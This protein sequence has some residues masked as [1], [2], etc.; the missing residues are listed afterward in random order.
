MKNRRVIAHDKVSSNNKMY[1][2]EKVWYSCNNSLTSY[3]K[4]VEYSIYGRVY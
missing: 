3:I 1:Y 4:C 2:V